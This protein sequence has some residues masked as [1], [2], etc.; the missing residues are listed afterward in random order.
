MMWQ[1]YNL[2]D[3]FR[4]WERQTM[5]WVS[6]LHS[7]GSKNPSSLRTNVCYAPL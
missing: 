6:R 5:T 3:S 2:G 4:F 7:F 1:R